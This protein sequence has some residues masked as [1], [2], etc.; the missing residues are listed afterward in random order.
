MIVETIKDTIKIKIG[1]FVNSDT[2]LS[3]TLPKEALFKGLKIKFKIFFTIFIITSSYSIAKSMYS[4]NFS[5]SEILIMIPLY[6][7]EI[8]P[9]SSL[10]TIVIL[11]VTSAIP[12]AA[13]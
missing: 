11:S 9:V 3:V 7:I 13:R 2:N 4:N 1:C 8:L 12:K 5:L 10:T 6:V